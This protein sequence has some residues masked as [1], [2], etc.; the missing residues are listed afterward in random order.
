MAPRKKACKDTIRVASLNAC[1]R[2]AANT[3]ELVHLLATKE[4]D[5]LEAQE[6][7]SHLPIS[8]TGYDWIPGLDRFL[9]PGH[10][11]GIGLLVKKHLRGLTSV[12]AIDKI[13]EF[14]WLK[15]AGHGPVQDTFICVLYC[16][17][18]KHPIERRK[19]FYAAL[20][21][22]CSLFM[23]K[24]EVLL[25]GDF[26]ARLGSISG[27]RGVINSNGK[28]LLE[29]LRSAFAD[30]DD[31]STYVSILN[32]CNGGTGT[33]TREETGKTSIIDYL[34]TAPESLRRVQNVHVEGRDQSSGVNAL[35]SDHNLLFVDWKLASKEP[36]DPSSNRIVKNYSRLQEPDIQAAYQA[37]LK[38][39]LQKWS[40]SLAPFTASCNDVNTHEDLIRKG[41]DSSHESLIK[42]IGIAEAAS[43]P[44][45][46][47][48]PN[49]RSWWDEELQELIELRSQAHED[50]K[51]H[52]KSHCLDGQVPDATYNLLWNKYVQLRR[53]SHTLASSK[54][55]Q[56]YQ[57]MLSNLETDYLSDRQHFFKE[58]LKI[59]RKKVP[60]HQITA[61]QDPHSRQATSQ[62]DEVKQ[63]LFELHSSLG[64]EDPNTD[65][66]EQPHYHTITSIIAAISPTEVGPNFCEKNISFAEIEDAISKAQNHKACGMDQIHNEALKH[67]GDA[68]IFAL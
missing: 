44:T 47:V 3:Q 62:P 52:S 11:L 25:M 24:G 23:A 9:R 68:I 17:T 26:K 64:K 40:L 27:D 6:V 20:L 13:H 39:E 63:I 58:I 50:W 41:L 65:K 7:K 56:Q 49:A 35:G 4:I 5:I 43:I 19:A 18:Q 57:N 46:C 10:H 2:L 31:D 60:N 32:A 59:R 29:F 37:A 61:L 55:N 28:L 22:S 53:R 8:I 34:I 51:R 21:E 42:H 36:D 67:G 16:L 66:F 15:L 33:P 54:R 45:K 14:M 1:G 30:G 12:V 38:S 48:N